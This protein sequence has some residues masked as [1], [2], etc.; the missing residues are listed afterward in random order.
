MVETLLKRLSDWNERMNG[1]P[2]KCLLIAI[3][4]LIAAVAIALFPYFWP[5]VVALVFSMILE[6]FVR[7]VSRGL[8]KL[9]MARSL[10]TLLGMLILFGVVTII[11]V[12]AISRLFRELMS[13]VRAVPGVISWISSTALPWARELYTQYQD[14][15]PPYAM[16]MV[17][18]ALGSLGQTLGQWAASISK[19]LTSGAWATAMSVVDV[20][21]SIVLTIMGTYYLTA[22]KSRIADFFRRT[23]PQGV[24]QHSVLIKTN[25]VKA[26]FGQV[27]SQL[28]VSC[29]IIFFLVASFM[30]YGVN[31]GL[32][33]A[34]IIGVA[35]ALPVI[36]AGLF[37]LPW[38][39]L[40]F[41]LGD[42][43]MGIFMACVY[44]GTIVIRQVLEPRI[45]GKN[46]GLY[47]LAT[48][49]AMYAGYRWLGFLGLIGGPIMLSLLKVVLE[50][51]KVSM[52]HTLALEPD[53]AEAAPPEVEA[54]P[55]SDGELT[56]PN[57]K[58]RSFRVKGK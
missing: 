53:A 38:S 35:D 37:L 6:P 12:A 20:I 5:F 52:A 16:D 26:L 55:K 36:G 15:L 57:G 19:A 41:V 4:L 21:L 29:V 23:F 30:I 25:L 58:K 39:I 43:S 32:M 10:A 24:R 14:I 33:A 45:V 34:L 44:V 1:V 56:L 2:R 48:M 40:S 9:K 3:T 50:A 47:P 51:D 7:L 17:N 8:E 28:T 22:D 42:V 31:Y 11:A 13:L 54:T 27:R 18:N 49:I 46:L